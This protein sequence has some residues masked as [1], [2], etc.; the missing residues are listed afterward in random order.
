VNY[1]LVVRGELGDQFAALF[2]GMQIFRENGTTAFCG[3]VR[4]QTHLAGIIERTQ[5]LGL[6]II[7]LSELKDDGLQL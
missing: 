4:D 7:S 6:E 2:E 5:D 1:R 3:P